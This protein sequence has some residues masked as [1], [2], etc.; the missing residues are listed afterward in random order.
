MDQNAKPVVPVK[1]DSPFDSRNRYKIFGILISIVLAFSI[2][3][4]SLILLSLNATIQTEGVVVL[5]LIRIAFIILGTPIAILLFFVGHRIDDAKNKDVS[6]RYP[7]WVEVVGMIIGLLLGLIV[8]S[9]WI[10]TF[11][12]TQGII[13]SNPILYLPLPV[14]APLITYLCFK[15]TQLIYALSNKNFLRGNF[16]L[17]LLIFLLSSPVLIYSGYIMFQIFQEASYQE[18]VTITNFKE[19]QLGNNYIFTA[20]MY[21]PQTSEYNITASIGQTPSDDIEGA[22]RINGIENI[23]GLHNYEL[24]KGMN[25]LIYYPRSTDCAYATKPAKYTYVTFNVRKVLEYRIPLAI[26]KRITEKIAC[27]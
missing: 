17:P 27:R 13:W 1:K 14:V 16:K 2:I 19:V 15:G 24:N 3:F 7:L 9:I 22:V 18:N 26:P 23:D 25:P 20:N 11:T 10:I 8:S 4:I 5:S 6:Y 12:L 21:V